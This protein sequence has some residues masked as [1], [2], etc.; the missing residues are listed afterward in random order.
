MPQTKTLHFHIP[1]PFT[2]NPSFYII[3]FFV[4]VGFIVVFLH[5]RTRQISAK[6]ERLQ[7][8]VD[9]KTADLETLVDELQDSQELLLQTNYTLGR[10]MSVL[11]H[12]VK[13]PLK[14]MTHIAEYLKSNAATTKPEELEQT[15]TSVVDSGNGM[16]TLMEDV[17]QWAKVQGTK[18]ELN[19]TEI[20]LNKKIEEEILFQSAPAK[21]KQVEIIHETKEA[22][23]LNTDGNLLSLIIQNLLSNAIKFSHEG[24]QVSIKAEK[25]KGKILLSVSDK[26]VGIPEEELK[27]LF[28]PKRTG[29]RI[30]T[31]GEKGS[32]IGLLI[33]KD[34]VS[35]IDGRI[36]AIS[37]EGQGTT[38]YVEL[39]LK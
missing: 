1:V 18:V 7:R 25:S 35:R 19:R 27:N 17:L 38:F 26:G 24:S 2:Q 21:Q 31:G 39:P 33:T 8:L 29:S 6:N 14:Y 5:V 28:N 22:L 15:L 4:A 16:V 13:G 36:W 12:N 30:G 3:L 34:L 9:E 32:G 23:A 37:R 11:S 20:P 10:I